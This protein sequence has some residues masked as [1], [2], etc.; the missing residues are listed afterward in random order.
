MSAIEIWGVLFLCCIGNTKRHCNAIR[1][2]LGEQMMNSKGDLAIFDSR[3]TVSRS[4]HLFPIQCLLLFLEV[5]FG[6]IF[7]HIKNHVEFV[8]LYCLFFI[9][10]H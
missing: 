5:F 10:I 3:V 1:V 6:S 2:Q 9:F 7:I 4:S 8:G